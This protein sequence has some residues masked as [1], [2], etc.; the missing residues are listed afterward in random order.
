MPACVQPYT[1]RQKPPAPP[2]PW[3]SKSIKA[4]YDSASTEGDSNNIEVSY[5]LEN[6][7]DFDYRVTDATNVTMTA[8]LARQ[9]ELSS[10]NEDS[11]KID[12]PIFIPAKK[13]VR[14]DIHINYQ[15]PVKQTLPHPDLE[16]RR[17]YRAGLEKYMSEELGNLD[18]FDFLDESSRYEIIFP[19]GWKHSK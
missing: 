3:D 6:T 15:Y 12:Y 14:F 7:T 18:G 16:E 4:E 10:F 1:N 17:K 13:R 19:A 8:K 11:G 5:T 2:K 9:N